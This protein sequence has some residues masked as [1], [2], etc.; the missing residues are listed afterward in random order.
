[1]EASIRLPIRGR[2]GANENIGFANIRED[3]VPPALSARQ[4]LV[5]PGIDSDCLNILHDLSHDFPV[6]PAITDKNALHNYSFRSGDAPASERA[7][8]KS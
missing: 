1:M 6:V 5:M 2:E 7:G 3:G 4:R 8:F